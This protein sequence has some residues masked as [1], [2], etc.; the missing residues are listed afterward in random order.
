MIDTVC[1]TCGEYVGDCFCQGLKEQ[2]RQLT[3]ER[4][5]LKSKLAVAREALLKLNFTDDKIMDF[6]KTRNTETTIPV[7]IVIGQIARQALEK[8]EEK[9]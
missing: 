3:E 1:D 2:I 4:D 9:P 5:A 6:M 8:L 7:L